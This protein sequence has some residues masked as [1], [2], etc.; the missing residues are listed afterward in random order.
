MADM[1]QVAA[2]AELHSLGYRGNILVRTT[3]RQVEDDE[4]KRIVAEQQSLNEV[5]EFHRK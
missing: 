1:V 5:L 3:T 2:I 4:R